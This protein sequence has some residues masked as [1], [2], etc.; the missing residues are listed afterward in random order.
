MARIVWSLLFAAILCFC[1]ETY[2]PEEVKIVGDLDYGQT[3]EPVEYTAT[4][5]YRA[6][7]FN[8]NSRDRIEV[9]VTSDDR[10]ATVAIADGSLKELINGTTTVTFTLPDKG[11]D[12][13]A[14]YIIFRDSEGKAGSFTVAL[15]KVERAR[16][17][18]TAE[19]ARQNRLC[20]AFCFAPGHEDTGRSWPHPYPRW[21]ALYGRASDETS[22]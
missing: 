19:T 18:S 5:G 12:P 14:Y 8:G 15:K 1:A 22:Q 10:K 3:S 9:T 6:F 7:V 16:A 4:P 21:T 20:A 2:P 17:W 13:E 11:P